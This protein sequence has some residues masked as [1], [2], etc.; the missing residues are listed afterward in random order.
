MLW[1]QISKAMI[2]GDI[3]L[4]GNRLAVVRD[5]A[6]NK[7]KYGTLELELVDAYTRIPLTGSVVAFGNECDLFNGGLDYG[8]KVSFNK[9]NAVTFELDLEGFD[10]PQVVDVL[11]AS[12]VYLS[13]PGDV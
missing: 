13:W 8:D 3:Q 6:P 7:M 5:E 12:D 2:E 4:H 10:Q 9:Y 11:H 1:D